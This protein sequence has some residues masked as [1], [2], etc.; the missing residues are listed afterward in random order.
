MIKKSLLPFCLLS[1]TTIDV[2]WSIVKKHIAL[3]IFQFFLMNSFTFIK[4]MRGNVAPQ[5]EQEELEN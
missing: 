3:A 5:Q 2:V 1:A 4:T